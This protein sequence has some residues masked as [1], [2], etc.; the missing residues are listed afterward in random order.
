[1]ASLD[2]ILV[3]WQLNGIVID[4]SLSVPKAKIQ[5]HPPPPIY[6]H[7]ASDRHTRHT[8]DANKANSN[9]WTRLSQKQHQDQPGL[10][11]TIDNRGGQH[12]VL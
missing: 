5:F 4:I 6:I 1:M 7:Q 8:P 10:V 12:G 2:L 9:C 3:Q 11:V